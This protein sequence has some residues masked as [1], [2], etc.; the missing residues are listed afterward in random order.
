M[1]IV[2]LLHLLYSM[3]LSLFFFQFVG[4]LHLLK[5]LRFRGWTPSLQ[6]LEFFII[7]RSG[8]LNRWMDVEWCF[9]CSSSWLIDLLHW[10]GCWLI[11]LMNI[12]SVQ[13]VSRPNLLHLS[14]VVI[15]ARFDVKFDEEKMIQHIIKESDDME[16]DE[17]NSAFTF[18]KMGA[19]LDE[20]FIPWDTKWGE[21]PDA[22]N[23]WA[24]NS[25]WFMKL[26]EVFN[27]MDD[28]QGVVKTI[29]LLKAFNG[30]VPTK[31]TKTTKAMKRQ[32]NQ[33]R[34]WSDESDVPFEKVR[35]VISCWGFSCRLQCFVVLTL[36]THSLW[37]LDTY[38]FSTL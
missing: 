9:C 25:H 19:L 32:R 16:C 8:T 1:L 33:W 11:N 7:K 23:V 36:T 24:Y 38:I 15:M 14:V 28:S 34:Q 31:A 30:E 21:L 3:Y 18:R 5:F 2:D 22:V 27:S 20:N 10:L 6:K 13:E 37:C 26:R 12:I 4:L 35:G 29:V 17:I